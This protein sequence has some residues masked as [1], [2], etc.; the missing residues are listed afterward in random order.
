M[1]LVSAKLSGFAAA[2][3]GAATTVSPVTAS[4]APMATAPIRPARRPGG[5]YLVAMLVIFLALLS[6]RRMGVPFLACSS[7]APG[8]QAH[9]H[10][11]PIALT[12]AGVV[13]VR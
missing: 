3:A 8:R 9:L 6:V 4:P 13:R 5:T 2:C 7:P 11:P 10:G 1:R 12:A